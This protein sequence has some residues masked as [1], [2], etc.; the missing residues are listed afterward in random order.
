MNKLLFP[1]GAALCAL[2]VVAVSRCTS[3]VEPDSYAVLAPAAFAEEAEAW[4]GVVSSLQQRYDAVLLRFE[5]SP[6]ELEAQL[7]EVA[8]RY[9]AVVDVPENIGRDYVPVMMLRGRRGWWM[10]RRSRCSFVPE[11]LLSRNW[12]PPSGLTPTLSW[13]IIRSGCAER[14]RLGRAR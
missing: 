8:P 9:V 13:M 6:M 3:E 5:E 14:R 11:W 12:R 2:F 4:E 7:K 10:M 1:L